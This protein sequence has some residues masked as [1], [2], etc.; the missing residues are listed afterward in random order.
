MCVKAK[1]KEMGHFK[2]DHKERRV[3]EYSFDYCLPRD[4]LG[5]KWT[6]LV[7]KERTSKGFMATAIAHK[8]GG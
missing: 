3:P 8:G 2:E 6:V 4:E 7:G 1:G 5:F